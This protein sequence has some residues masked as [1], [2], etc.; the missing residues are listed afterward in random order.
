M[1]ESSD[2]IAQANTWKLFLCFKDKGHIYIAF[3]YLGWFPEERKEKKKE[4]TNFAASM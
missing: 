1:D 4:V 2:S 3:H